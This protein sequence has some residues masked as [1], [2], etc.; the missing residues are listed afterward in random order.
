M[1][2][3]CARKNCSSLK[4][5]VTVYAYR[6]NDIQCDPCNQDTLG[7]SFCVLISGV[8]YFGLEL[9]DIMNYGWSA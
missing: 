5:A 7:Q 4:D 3:E 1:K 8:M 2:S 9:M 6:Y